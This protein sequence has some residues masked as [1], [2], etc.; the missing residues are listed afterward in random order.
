MMV[1]T[2]QQLLPGFVIPYFNALMQLG[3]DF[4]GAWWPDLLTVVWT[5]IKVM[6]IILPLLGI[7]AYTTFCERK[8]I[9]WMQVRIGPN[10]VGP[11][12]LIQPLA[13]GLK[14]ML[15]EVV[16]PSGADKIVFLLA[17]VLAFGPALIAWAVIP[18]SDVL[19]VAN[20]NASLLYVLAVTSM[21]VYG[22]ILAGW[23]SN[24]KYAF[25]GGMRSAAQ[26]ISY[27]VAMGLALVVVVMVSNSLNLGDIVKAQGQGR[28]A[29]MG[30]TFLSWNWL[31]LLPMFVVYV[32]S[33]V[34]ETNRAPFDMAEGESEI[35]GYHVEYSGMAFA[36]FQLAEYSAMLMCST[37]ISTLFLGGWLSPVA[38]LPDSVFW[39]FAKIGALVF[40]FF[41]IRATF[42]RYRYDQIMRLGWKVFIPVC[43]VWLVVVGCWMMSPWNIWK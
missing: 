24:S 18:F 37:L 33:S 9:G 41:W 17:P 20:V 30:L 10:R 26:L 2:L 16:I 23:A 40:F 6:I 13:D 43:L 22:I 5:V 39:L 34:A 31:C 25:L 8:V 14:L 27:E 19:I 36:V 12:G 38:F 1:E 28:F 29:D 4:F 21:G 15:K 35:V 7:V 32:V 42:P 3:Q 11:W